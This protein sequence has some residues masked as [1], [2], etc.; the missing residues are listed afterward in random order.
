MLF[1]PPLYVST[2]WGDLFLSCRLLLSSSY[3]TF[4]FSPS[5]IVVNTPSLNSPPPRLRLFVSSALL[6]FVSYHLPR[7]L[8]DLVITRYIRTSTHTH[9]HKSLSF[10]CDIQIRGLAFMVFFFSSSFFCYTLLQYSSS[11]FPPP[12]FFFVFFPPFGFVLVFLWV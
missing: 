12:P 5:H 3:H 11:V 7:L 6:F 10:A 9:I 1:N 4:T 2:N 8:H